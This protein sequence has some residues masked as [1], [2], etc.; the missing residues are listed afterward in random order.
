[1][2]VALREVADTHSGG[3]AELLGEARSSFAAGAVAIEEKEELGGSPKPG[4]LA[5]AEGGAEQSDRAWAAGLSEAHDCPRALDHY[6]AGGSGGQGP[7]WVVEDLG[8][9]EAGREAPLAPAGDVVMVE[10]AATVAE[11][12]AADVMQ[13]NGD[14]ASE[15]GAAWARDAA[16]N[17]EAV[18]AVMPLRCW[19]KG[20]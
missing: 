3:L 13:T 15:E 16:S 14:R 19:R 9:G 1:V 17:R 7:V 10:A 8:L 5:G 6:D 18:S 20:G 12:L 11:G 2:V 4:F